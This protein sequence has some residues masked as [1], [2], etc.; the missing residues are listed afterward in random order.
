[1]IKKITV[2]PLGKLSLQKH[3]H[4]SEHW[5]IVKGIAK[6]T[7]EQSI[8][9]LKMNESIFIPQKAK[10]RIENDESTDLVIIEIQF[11]NILREDD[12]IRYEDIYNRK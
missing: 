5:V 7:I 1:M 10:H 8:K 9:K 3:E 12:I 4:R 2:N 11:G 6:I